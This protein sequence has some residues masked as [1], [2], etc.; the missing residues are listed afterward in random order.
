MKVPCF[1]EFKKRLSEEGET[2]GKNGGEALV[3][4]DLRAE[5]LKM[6]EAYPAKAIAKAK[7]FALLA[8]KAPLETEKGNVFRARLNA[9]GLMSEQ[10][11]RWECEVK[12]AFLKEESAFIQRAWED[13]GAYRG[14]GDYGHTSPNTKLLLSKGFAGTLER[15]EYYS[16]KANLTAEQNDF[17]LSCKIVLEAMMTAAKRLSSAIEPYDKE[18]AASLLRIANGAPQNS[19]DAMQ[20]LLFYF[21]MH[22]YVG[23]TRVRTLGRLDVLLAPFYKRDLASGVYT[24]EQIKD[25]LK[26]FLYEFWQ[27]KVPFG[28]PFCL[29]GVDDGGNEVTDEISYLIVEAFDSLSIESP[30]IHVRVSQ[31]TPKEFLKL[32][33]DCIRRGNSSFVF[34]ND[35]IGVEALMRIGIEE[36]DAK[37]YVPIGCYEPA[38]WGVEMGCTGNGGVN[39]VKAIEC[40]VNGGKDL[41]NDVLCGLPAELPTTYESFLLALKSQISYMTE[42]GMRYIVEMEKHYREI[43][44]DP[45]LSAQ[46]DRS[47]ERGLDVYEGGAKYNNSSFYFYGIASLVDSICAVKTLVFEEKR[48]SFADFVK[49]L[50]NDW[51]GYEKER[52]AA[53]RLPHK[54]GNGDPLADALTEEMTKFCATL[55]NGKANGRGGVFKAA[56]FSINNCFH[57]GSKTM[58]TPDGRHAGD[59]L[60]KNLCATVG[61]DRKGITALISSVTKIDH[62][63]FP[64]GSVLDVVF[65]PTAVSGEDGLEAFYNILM[66]YLKKGGFAM[67]GNVFDT[68]TLKK[69][70]ANPKEYQ[71]LQVRLCGWNAYFVNLSKAEQDSFIKQSEN[72]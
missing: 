44:P 26:F 23:G 2:V 14:I 13:Y 25:L 15:I 21:F 56:L 22:E 58:A 71:N 3:R 43:N 57:L 51:A 30:K 45:L 70:Q 67:H 66:I 40:A 17:Y 28:L 49:M 16:S 37:D 34:V 12:D 60:S 46:Y 59:P 55:A 20:L 10:R 8:E 68:E 42:R 29:G 41:K 11:W 52:Q 7:T 36:R 63:A 27:A 33:L 18:H 54:Y 1:E 64:N 19:Y 72:L 61:M 53:C 69:A 62:V 48:F 35:R 32:V 31:K 24:K 6:E 4:E 38:V 50:K 9:F 65:H 5:I 47:V 39:L